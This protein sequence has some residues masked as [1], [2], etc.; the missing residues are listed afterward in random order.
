MCNIR[1][2]LKTVSEELST[3]RKNFTF[4]LGKAVRAGVALQG[5][6]MT[7]PHA[8]A[9]SLRSYTRRRRAAYVQLRHSVQQ[10][11]QQTA[12]MEKIRQLEREADKRDRELTSL[13]SEI[14][15]L[16]TCESIRERQLHVL[17][18]AACCE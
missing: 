8:E 3:M 12:R 4:E 1:A 10:G 13:G 17:T 9:T 5:P 7:Q 6:R 18:R 15:A 16:Q 14:S 2:E 11:K